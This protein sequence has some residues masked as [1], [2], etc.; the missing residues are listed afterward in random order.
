MLIVFSFAADNYAWYGCLKYFE[1]MFGTPNPSYQ[2]RDED[3][4][5]E[6]PSILE[7]KNLR[8]LP[9]GG[10]YILDLFNSFSYTDCE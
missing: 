6:E 10:L 5:P 3:D 4:V 1:R 9:L 8:I 7:N 2:K